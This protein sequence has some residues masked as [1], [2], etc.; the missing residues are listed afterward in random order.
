MF[1]VTLLKT[2]VYISTESKV[3]FILIDLDRVNPLTYKSELSTL[4][5]SNAL[6]TLINNKTIQRPRSK[7]DPNSQYIDVSLDKEDAEAV[8]R[9]RYGKLLSS[10]AVPAY[11][12]LNQT[13]KRFI[14][15]YIQ[16]MYIFTDMWQFKFDYQEFFTYLFSG[17]GFD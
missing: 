12:F 4:D 17:Y 1:A 9:V 2:P 15:K 8:K 7:D 3:T 5:L 14:K 13:T 6:N 16:S 10:V 11:G